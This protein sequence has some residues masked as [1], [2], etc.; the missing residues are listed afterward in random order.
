[1]NRPR[2][3]SKTVDVTTDKFSISRRLSSLLEIQNGYAFDSKKFGDKGLPLVRIR[4]LRNGF[5]TET[6]FDGEFDE[7]YIVRSGDFLI[8]MD[9]E[10]ACYEWKGEDALLN[11]RV[12]KLHRFSQQ[13]HP[14][15]LFLGI[16]RYLKAIEDTTSYT[17]VKHISSRQILDIEMPIPSL[18]EQVRIVK[19][20]DEAFDGIAKVAANSQQSLHDAQSLFKNYLQSVVNQNHSSWHAKPLAQISREFGRGKSKHRPRNDPKL[21]KGVYP[22]VQ[23]GDIS[24]ASHWL[25][26]YKQTYS[27]VGLAQSRLWPKGT[28]CIAIVGAT[29]GETAILN[30]SACFPD[31]VIGIVV[32]ERIADNEYVEY[33]LQASKSLLKEKGK[34]TARDNINLGTFEDHKFPFPPLSQQK[35][36]VAKINALSEELGFLASIGQKKI[37]ALEELKRSLLDQAFSGNL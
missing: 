26:S 30:F 8:G 14:R 1:M 36:T 28:V 2:N 19:I 10:F 27:E 33:L 5:T 13:V 3:A 25:T 17:T 21:Y 12:C 31:S 16:S 24:N 22:F 9:G 34:G 7:R 6:K 29:V 4:D 18:R 11:Q 35:K 37:V 15:F 23:T 32:D 20:L